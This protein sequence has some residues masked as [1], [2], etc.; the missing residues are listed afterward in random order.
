MRKIQE[1]DQD[2]TI[3]PSD[4]PSQS[5]T[6][7]RVEVTKGMRTLGVRLAPNGND[8]DEYTYRMEQGN[9]MRDKLK[10]APLNRTQV[11]IGFNA[12]W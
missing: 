10:T 3:S 7:K 1:E 12:I 11:G 4:D 6:V 8:H 9:M 5:Q 2:I